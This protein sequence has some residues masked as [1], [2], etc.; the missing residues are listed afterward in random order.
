MIIIN[1]IQIIILLVAMPI[2]TFCYVKYYMA[3]DKFGIIQMITALGMVI[4]FIALIVANIDA[5]R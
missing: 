4:G 2:M 3:K 1:I 5:I